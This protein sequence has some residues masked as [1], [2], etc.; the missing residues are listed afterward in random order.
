MRGIVLAAGLGT[1][2]KSD[3]P[4]VLHQILGKPMLWY[5]LTNLR[6]GGV[7][8][9]A[10]VVGH[11]AEEVE[12]RFKGERLHFF[13]QKNPKGGTGDAVL[14]AKDFFAS[15]E[16]YVIVVNGDSPLVSGETI[17]NL[18]QFIY[19]VK[20]YEGVHLSGVVLTTRLPD[21]TGYGRIVREEGTDRVLRIVEEKDATPQEKTI[22]EVNAGLY[23]FWAPHLLEALYSIKP[24]PVTGELYLTDVINYLSS[25]GYEVRAF[26]AKDPT[27]ALGVNTRWELSIAE[28][29]IKLKLVKFWSERGVTFHFPE[30]VWIEPDVSLER[31]VEV[32][33]SVALKGRTKVRKGA[34]I[35]EGSVLKDAVVEEG[36]VVGEYSVIEKSRVEKGAKVGPFARVREESTVGE[37][38]EVGNF[39]EVKKSTLGKGTRAKHLAYIGDATLGEGVNVGAGVV[40]ANYDGKR[41][42]PTF[43]GDK[44]FIGSNALLVA[45]LKLGR[46]TFVAGGTVVTQ[47]LPDESF[48]I[49][50]PPLVIKDKVGRKFLDTEKGDE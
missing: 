13:R 41:K 3:K 7:D 29:V 27:E 12:E 37:G 11:K 17:K 16:G 15:Y 43:V 20:Q 10:V 50:R 23:A 32:F 28:N 6:N 21:P 44:A 22:T 36:A 33:P 19:M 39:V 34:V 8:E 9:I 25:K 18:Q 35:K 45:P 30:T 31:D 5:V 4:K 1:R 24:S 38:A 47:D 48:A 14:A 49:S 26:Q 46:Y 40:F 42:H 2:F